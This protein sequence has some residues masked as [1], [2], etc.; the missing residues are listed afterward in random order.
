MS[1]HSK[2]GK[3][4]IRLVKRGRVWV[5]ERD[6]KG[7]GEWI[8]FDVMGQVREARALARYQRTLQVL[9]FPFQDFRQVRDPWG[10]RCRDPKTGEWTF[11][12]TCGPVPTD[13]IVPAPLAP[14]KTFATSPDGVRRYEFVHRVV[15]AASLIT[16]HD[17][18]TFQ[19]NPAFS[20]VIQPRLRDRAAAELQVKKIAANL[21]PEALLTDFHTLDR[22]APIIGPDH[23][24]ESGNGRAMGIMRA[25]QD[26]PEVYAAYKSALGDR[27]KTYGFGPEAAAKIKDPVLVRV[28]VTRLTP[29]Q[30]IEFVREANLPPGISRSAVEQARTDAEKITL[31]ML[32]G[33]EIGENESL[34][35]ALRA[36]RNNNFVRAFLSGLPEN[37]QAQLVDAKGVINMDGVRR[38]ANAVFVS[39]FGAGEPGLRLGEMAFESV[40]QDVKN[41]FNGLARSIASLARAESLVRSQQRDTDLS[42]SGD[43]AS[44]V[45][46]YAKIRNTPGMTV[47][48][49]L[50]QTQLLDRELSP[51]QER[52]LQDLAFNIRSSKRLGTIFRNYAEAVIAQPPPSQSGLFGPVKGP[53]KE[54]LWE[55]AVANKDRER[56][57]ALTMQQR[58]LY[59]LQKGVNWCNVSEAGKLRIRH[60]APL[61]DLVYTASG[62]RLGVQVCESGFGGDQ[63]QVTIGGPREGFLKATYPDGQQSQQLRRIAQRMGSAAREVRDFSGRTLTWEVTVPVEEKGRELVFKPQI[64]ERERPRV[65]PKLQPSLFQKLKPRCTP[66]Q[67][68]RLERCIQ[69][70]KAKGGKTNP[71]A[72]C[73]ASIGCRF[74]AS[75]RGLPTINQRAPCQTPGLSGAAAAL[76]GCRKGTLM[77]AEAEL[78]ARR[79][80]YNPG[81]IDDTI[82]AARRLKSESDLYVFPTGRGLAI[83][84]KKPPFGLQYYVVH[85]DGSVEFVPSTVSR[86]RNGEKPRMSASLLDFLMHGIAMP[87]TATAAATWVARKM[88]GALA[89]TSPEAVIRV[90]D[91]RKAVAP[92]YPAPPAPSS[93]HNP[94]TVEGDQAEVDLG[95]LLAE[96]DVILKTP[97]KM[98]EVDPQK[99]QVTKTGG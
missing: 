84:R 36:S 90:V 33:L 27:G 9:G 49:Y 17:P 18:F 99:L 79:V 83:E 29:E 63:Y 11:G 41:V 14:Q 56:E 23:L 86:V 53:G 77:S 51:F 25:I 28:R 3:G 26:H 39:A 74:P 32:E 20:Q 38:A 71:W 48:T 10:S 88:G 42:I 72:V 45:Q 2:P 55:L 68:T 94:K 70:V 46:V 8:D 22:G 16:S 31:S 95:S 37:E 43:L 47:A 57:P 65:D 92:A 67:A 59:L 52:M 81:S 78:T 80:R 58:V 19:V 96:I 64:P 54:R 12:T 69:A 34:F 82:A 6:F 98:G 97:G 87:A 89:V 13:G 21:S 50:A 60:W 44:V 73:T 85:P 76:L 75:R 1:S 24:V 15:P 66:A 30:R 40:D 61:R 62:M 93:V 7:N 35:D 91:D 5:V 4:N